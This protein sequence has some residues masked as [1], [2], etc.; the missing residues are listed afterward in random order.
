VER[1]REHGDE[2]EKGDAEDEQLRRAD[3]VLAFPR[4]G[5]QV[6][7]PDATEDEQAAA[8]EGQPRL[9]ASRVVERKGFDGVLAN[10]RPARS[11]AAH[12]R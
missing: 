9:G 3:A 4:L 8:L 2:G 12:P 11:A 1:E 5:K 6:E 10:M 7:T